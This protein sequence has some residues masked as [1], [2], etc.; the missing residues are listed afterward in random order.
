MDTIELRLILYIQ[1]LGL[2][3]RNQNDAQRL[4]LDVLLDRDLKNTN[5]KY[6]RIQCSDYPAAPDQPDVTLNTGSKNKY[7][8]CT[9]LV[10]KDWGYTVQRA[11]CVWNRTHGLGIGTLPIS[12][13]SL[14]STVSYF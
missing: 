1:Y 2:D 5:V 9:V 3:Y 7:E 13:Y 14:D 12:F 4:C 10:Y 11:T 8:S 6:R